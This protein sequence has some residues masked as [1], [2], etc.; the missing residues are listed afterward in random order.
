MPTQT[1]KANL[2]FPD[3]AKVSV[4]TT[5]DSVY[6]DL[7]AIEQ[8]INTS[9]TYTENQ[10]TTANAGK[11][12]KQ[13]KDMKIEGSFNLID[14]DYANLARLGGG[15]FTKVDTPASANSSI[16]DQVIAAG[17]ADNTIYP[18]EMLTSSTD[19]TPLNMGTT[20]P[21]LTSV[22]LDAGGTPEVL[23]EDTDY[24]IVKLPE[25]VSKW[26]PIHI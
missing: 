11:T 18:L 3:G 23:A 24:V 21:T 4:K 2:L 5:S 8:D 15:L 16:P 19:S 1:T 13:I 25:A 12:A 7:G 17:W 26:D 22:T 10:I 14:Y 9:L 6:V 20:Q